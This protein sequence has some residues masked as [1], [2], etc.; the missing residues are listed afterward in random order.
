MRRRLRIKKPTN[1]RRIS[2]C[3]SDG[4]RKFMVDTAVMVSCDSKTCLFCGRFDR[5]N[6]QYCLFCGSRMVAAKAQQPVDRVQARMESVLARLEQALPLIERTGI[7]VDRPQFRQRV[8][9]LSQRFRRFRGK[10]LANAIWITLLFL[11][12]SLSALLLILIPRL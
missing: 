7:R 8:R 10:R 3:S 6:D 2:S 4:E 11:A 5:L 12:V 1:Q 9:T